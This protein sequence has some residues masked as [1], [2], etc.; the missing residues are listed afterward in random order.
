[1]KEKVNDVMGAFEQLYRDHGC[2]WGKEPDEWLNDH[3]WKSE[4]DD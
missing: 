2:V 1:L 3:F 4:L